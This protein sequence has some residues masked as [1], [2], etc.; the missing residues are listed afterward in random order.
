MM[1]TSVA[2][3]R[4]S[5]EQ[6]KFVGKAL[7]GCNILVDACIGSGKTTA[8]QQLCCAFP[9]DRRILYLTYNRLLKEDAK[10]KIGNA[11]NVTVTNYHGFAWSILSRDGIS[12]GIRDLIRSFNQ[13]KPA[14]PTYDVL[15]LDEYQDIDTELAEMLQYIK[16]TNP[17]MQRIAVGDMAQKVYDKTTLDIAAF[18]RTFLEDP[19]ELC[20]TRC[21]RLSAEYAA[22]LS[23]VWSKTIV[24]VNQDSCVEKMSFQEAIDFLAEQEPGDLLCLGNRTGAL[25][26]A[27][28]TLE[29][30]C[31]TRFNKNTVYASIWDADGDSPKREKGTAIFTTFD[32]CK[33][34]ERPICAVF[35]FTEKHWSNR[36]RD[37]KV[38]YN[39][40]R[41]IFCV[42]ASRGKWRTIFVEAGSELLSEKTLCAGLPE[43]T[44]MCDMNISEMF[45]FKFEED[46]EACYALLTV[47]PVAPIGD[48]HEI[49][50]NSRDAMIDLSPCIGLYQ[51]AAFFG[52]RSLEAQI[53]YITASATQPFPEE[54]QQSGLTLDQKILRIMAF[55]TRQERYCTQVTAPFVSAEEREQLCARLAERLSP[56]ERVQ[57]PCCIAFAATE[58]GPEI[59]SVRGLADAVRDKTV[60]E[61]KFVSEL[62]HEHFLQCACYMAALD[63]PRGILWNI[64]RNAAFSISIADKRAFWDAV[65]RT[66]TKRQLSC[67]YHPE[68]VLPVQEERPKAAKHK[69]AGPG[70]KVN[71]NDQFIAVIDTETNDI[72]KVMSLG[73]VIA[74]STTFHPL[75]KFYYIIS[76]AAQVGGMY[77]HVLEHPQAGPALR[78]NRQEVMQQVTALLLEH[79]SPRIFAYNAKFDQQ[80]LEELSEFAWYDIMKLAS[81]K[82]FN[83]S[84]EE[85]ADLCK[86]GR[87]KKD[88]G[89][90]HMIR[91]LRGTPFYRETHNALCDALDELDIMRLLE[92]PLPVYIHN[93]AIGQYEE[94]SSSPNEN[95]DAPGRA[96]SHFESTPDDMTC[97][98]TIRENLLKYLAFTN[99]MP[100]DI[101]QESPLANYQA[102]H[103]VILHAEQTQQKIRQLLEKQPSEA[104]VRSVL[105]EYS[106]SELERVLDKIP[107]AQMQ[108]YQKGLRIAPLRDRGFTTMKQIYWRSA[109]DLKAIDGIGTKTAFGIC[110]AANRIATEAFQKI[111]L[112]PALHPTSAGKKLVHAY[113]KFIWLTKI[114]QA[115][116]QPLSAEEAV[117]QESLAATVPGRNRFSWLLTLSGRKRQAALLS[118]AALKKRLISQTDVLYKMAFELCI[119]GDGIT[120]AEAWNDYINAPQ[121]YDRWFEARGCLPR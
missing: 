112:H 83:A 30:R 99:K 100:G 109:R 21:F 13:N 36:A 74:D 105:E 5:P 54:L 41:N 26:K 19:V 45:D 75:K 80:H 24:G 10:E 43:R 31:P 57:V 115:I 33:G 68:I 96:V 14:I 25:A 98:R 63:L 35:D 55:Q 94:A 97:F 62:T 20:F 106:R 39:I 110:A 42:A 8:I 48:T 72:D 44:A 108:A 86:T 120:A 32:S 64:R 84:I 7:M 82:K 114:H 15:I 107:V 78:G 51:E 49:Q 16:S 116:D 103:A 11:P 65:A 93:A 111:S 81:Y 37:P 28:N 87:L 70:I 59:F 58:N 104:A 66:I 89:V 27:L 34:L 2:P 121:E 73:I 22:K 77:S 3:V 61:L 50:I 91:R 29:R 76:E 56:E 113:C 60:Y 23:N 53:R 95:A 117:L 90:E 47:S 18:I 101:D 92:Q 4:L 71:P 6:S 79:G 1:E 12:C 40:T 102:L 52:E 88:Y 85:D 17:S 38:S 9:T 69:K 119:L 46:V 67:Y 118:A